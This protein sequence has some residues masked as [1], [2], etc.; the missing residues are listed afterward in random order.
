MMQIAKNV[1]L[2][3]GLILSTLNPAFAKG[4]PALSEKI[5]RATN[6]LQRAVWACENGAPALTLKAQTVAG[7]RQRFFLSNADR[8]AVQRDAAPLVL[9][10]KRLQGYGQVSN[11]VGWFTIRFECS[12]SAG[13]DR[14]TSFTFEA[15]APIPPNTSRP[16]PPTARAPAAEKRTWYTEGAGPFYLVH[17]IAET[18]D[19]DFRAGCVKGSP[20]IKVE[21]ANT[22][23]GLKPRDAITV[24]ISNGPDSGLYVARGVL[25]ENVGSTLPVFAVGPNDHLPDWIGNGT[26]LAVNIGGEVA[27]GISLKGSGPA[28]KAFA[29]TCGR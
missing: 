19:R 12:L 7:D 2:G 3:C 26:S 16:A 10:G 20:V 17:G 25:D 4:A 29:A 5:A 15:L 28:I 27:Y 14:A 8:S 9:E 24:S 18:D 23:Q 21:L 6:D 11:K 13:L 1:V 22:V